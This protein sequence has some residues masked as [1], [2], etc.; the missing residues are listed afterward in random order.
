[1]PNTEQ[2]K[3]GKGFRLS[4]KVTK[5]LGLDRIEVFMATRLRVICKNYTWIRP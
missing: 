5:A 2:A 4:V 3:Q 1:M